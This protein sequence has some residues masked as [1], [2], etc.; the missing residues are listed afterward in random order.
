MKHLGPLATLLA[1]GALAA[2]VGG[3]SVRAASQ[4]SANTTAA[5]QAVTA[6][7][8]TAGT[9]TPGT[10]N[11]AGT[12]GATPAGVAP[13][14]SSPEQG[15]AASPPPN[16]K[17][18]YAG[19]TRGGAATLA[20]AVRGDKA[21]AYLCDG[22]VVESW[23]RG[24]AAEGKFTL[25]GKNGARLTAYDKNGKITGSVSARGL[26]FDFTVVVVKRPSG[27]YRLTAEVRGARLDGGWIVMP[28]GRQIGVLDTNGTPR[29]APSLNT[30]TG[31][32]NVN[33]ENVPAQEVQP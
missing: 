27:L 26:S 14:P 10:G 9:G 11:G 2:T 3:L 22:K 20:I 17:R 5:G 28:D 23:L 25:S 21:I 29:P 15:A 4:D 12:S 33:G 19:Y 32:V 18:D 7:G 1:G 31:Q 13:S 16:I 30:S 24:S 6:G 8:S